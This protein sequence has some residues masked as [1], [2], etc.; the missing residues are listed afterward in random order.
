MKPEQFTGRVYFPKSSGVNWGVFLTWLVVP[1]GLAGLLAGLLFW[2]F[3]VGH[4]YI[5]IMP[6]VAALAVGGCLKLA[7][8][9]G[10]CRN[11]PVAIAAGVCAGLLLYLG[12]Y[13]CG[14]VYH[15]G[16]AAARRPDLLPDYIRMRI[17]TD[18]LRDAHDSRRDNDTARRKGSAFINWGVFAVETVIV[19]G[20]TTAAG[21]ARARK[22][23]CEIC[24]QWMVREITHFDPAQT[25]GLMA[26]FRS[27]SARALA[28]LG[29]QPAFATFPCAMLAV[30]YCPSVRDGR[31]RDCPVY[32]S[33]KRVTSAVG[34]NQFLDAFDS[35]QGKVL[36]RSLQ[37]NPDEV[38]ALGSRFKVFESLAG[39]AAVTALMP[40][41][42]AEEKPAAAAGAFVDV[43]PVEADCAGRVLT[44]RNAIIGTALTFAAVL[45]LFAGPGL[46]AWGGITA[47]PDDKSS[48]EVSPERKAA[49]IAALSLGGVLF[50]A[51]AAFFFVNP[52]WLGNR[53][54]LK[55]VQREFARRAGCLVDLH[56]PDALFVEIVPKLNWGKLGWENARDVGF[57]RVDKARREILF[58][59]DQERWRIP[60][61]AIT[62]CDVE[63]FV[64]GQGTH[65]ATKI[66]YVVL[67]ARHPSEF[68]EAPIRERTGMGLFRSGQ[69]KKSAI[70]LC[71]AIRAIQGG[72]S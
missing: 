71:E 22:S 53:Y 5:I 65:A 34:S 45:L 72:G 17:Q 58:E 50:F 2:L 11:R 28:G 25:E 54:L 26:A 10:H 37:L 43:R 70:R 44:K 29:A 64:E 48:G 4:Y 35:S 55:T 18:V 24:R 12:Y 66:F 49:G 9:K 42:A 27:S 20:F 63:F 6:A 62:H 69:R 61:A 51:T 30:E 52:T 7:I 40:E 57:L 3:S 16:P 8:G 41:A 21:L 31:A 68:W 23:Y 33:L 38:A 36:I 67:R 60:A 47:F 1:F 15:F 19:L 56:D 14:M 32:A 46:A 13:Y 59:G 39:R